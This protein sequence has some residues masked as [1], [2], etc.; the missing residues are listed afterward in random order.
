M[1]AKKKIIKKK[2]AKKK[3]AKKK[4]AKKKIAKKKVIDKP[5]T[6]F[7]AKKKVFAEEYLMDLN[8][9][10]AAIR[11]GY[12]EKTAKSQ[13]QRLLT[14]VD[15]AAYIAK[16]KEERS[17][18]TKI[19]ADWLLKRLADEAEAD[20]ADLYNEAGGL[21]PVH[22]WPEIWR[23][24]LVAGLDVHQEYEYEDGQKIP[25]G[26][27]MKVRLSDRIKRLELI[28]KHVDV[29]AFPNK[30]EHSGPKGGPI[31]QVVLD[32]DEYKKM[33]E[34]MIKDDDV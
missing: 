34:E 12:S 31:E 23:K 19:D 15:V 2:A 7:T 25:D 17:E 3:T 33:R 26:M 8:A 24:G 29:Q 20:V 27:I 5:K 21:K 30:V 13:G 6:I 1:A 9:T 22:E 4:T 28:G 32:K 11:A 18:R 10:Q 14:D 16:G